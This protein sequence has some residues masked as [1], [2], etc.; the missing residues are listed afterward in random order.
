MTLRPLDRRRQWRHKLRNQFQTWLLIAGSLAVLAFVALSLFGWEGV[1]WAVLGGGL[2]LIL[3]AQVNPRMVLRLY[4]ARPIPPEAAP[5]LN[6]IMRRLTARADLP[7][8]PELHYI[9]SRAMNAFAV[10]RPEDSAIAV[11]DGLLRQLSLRELTGVLAHEVSHIRNGDL[12]VMAV[13]DV[14]ARMTSVMSSAGLFLLFIYLPSLLASGITVPW[15]AILALMFAPTI[16][17]LLQLALSRAREYD[18]DLDA[19]G[20]TGDPEGLAAALRIL[21]ER[22]GRAWEGLVLPSPRVPVPSILRTHPPTEKRIARLLS[23]VGERAAEPPLVPAQ[24]V[25]MPTYF[26]P[27]VR[28]PRYRASGLWY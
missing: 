10:G 21:E 18:A 3:G 1:L 5:E 24:R 9:A 14:V 2:S 19:A 7:A 26:I 23:L 22:Q 4:R 16:T 11:T 25:S 13:A 6:A 28:P 8:V 17:G 20:M 27:V 12:K 15:M